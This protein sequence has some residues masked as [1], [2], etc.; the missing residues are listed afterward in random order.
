MYMYL[1]WGWC[2]CT[3]WTQRS[4][5]R[6][7][8]WGTQP[9]GTGWHGSRSAHE[10]L[11]RKKSGSNISLLSPPISPPSLSFSHSPSLLMS[12]L[13]S[14][15]SLT[16]FCE[17]WVISNRHTTNMV[18]LAGSTSWR[19]LEEYQTYHNFLPKLYINYKLWT[20]NQCFVPPLMYHNI[21]LNLW[22]YLA[23]LKFPPRSSTSRFSASTSFVSFPLHGSSAHANSTRISTTTPF[24]DEA[25]ISVSQE[26]FSLRFFKF[27]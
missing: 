22:M 14:L 18:S 1:P 13:F 7:A 26:I 3:G 25:L 4:R 20:I 6:Q 17:A 21:I 11:T 15:S 23:Q 12:S 5:R 19:T 27:A 16:A 2:I 9:Q 10:H 8:A 24:H